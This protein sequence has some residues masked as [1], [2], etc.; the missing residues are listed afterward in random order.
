MPPC[1][2]SLQR[3]SRQTR[4][5]QNKGPLFLTFSTFVTNVADFLALPKL[6]SLERRR[7]TVSP[8][9][10]TPYY[11]SSQISYLVVPTDNL[12]AFVK[13]MDILSDRS[14]VCQVL[15]IILNT[16]HWPYILHTQHIS[17]TPQHCL[18]PHPKDF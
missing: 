15:K 8:P 13:L 11:L 6:K 18:C 9:D 12:K 17:E 3:K 7:V 10:L 1:F 16:L 4:D 14:D 5:N 2:V